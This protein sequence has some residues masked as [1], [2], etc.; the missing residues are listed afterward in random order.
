MLGLGMLSEFSSCPS[1]NLEIDLRQPLWT[2]RSLPSV[3]R[4]NLVT[5]A[6]CILVRTLF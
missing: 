1:A 6:Q 2:R 5:A 3:R 4:M